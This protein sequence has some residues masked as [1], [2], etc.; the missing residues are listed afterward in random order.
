[1]GR[2]KRLLVILMPLC[3]LAAG[4]GSAAGDPMTTIARLHDCRSECG[5]GGECRLDVVEKI[6]V[7]YGSRRGRSCGKNGSHIAASGLLPPK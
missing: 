4:I 3:G 7:G 1:V 6:K 5:A 2:A